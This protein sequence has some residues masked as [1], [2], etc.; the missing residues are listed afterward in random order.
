[1]RLALVAIVAL[2]LAVAVS[3]SEPRRVL[4][5]KAVRVIPVGWTGLGIAEPSQTLT[6][7]LALTLR[8]TKNLEDRF[9]AVSNPASPF[10]TEYSTLEELRERYAPSPKTLARITAFL[11]KHNAENIQMT[12]S[13]DWV[14]F[15]INV[16][17]A[18]SMF[19]TKFAR[20]RHS[21]GSEVIRSLLVPPLFSF[22]HNPTLISE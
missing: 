21:S 2:A 4:E 3:A 19:A 12:L 13:A 16:S 17:N 15:T 1:M 20:F 11:E 8:N 14:S 9:W 5:H 10:Y 6:L 7:S 18:E 22:S